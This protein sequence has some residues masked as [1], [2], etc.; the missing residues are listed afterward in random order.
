MDENDI[1]VSSEVRYS[2]S[3]TRSPE[4][5][6]ASKKGNFLFVDKSFGSFRFAVVDINI[7]V[8]FTCEA[9][10]T[11]LTLLTGDIAFPFAFPL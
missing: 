4:L 8:H 1:K 6:S 5:L 2:C 11:V 3:L 7:N 10:N 9:A